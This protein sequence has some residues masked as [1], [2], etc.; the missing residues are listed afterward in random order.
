MDVTVKSIT[1]LMN[2]TDNSFIPLLW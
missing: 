2:S 1:F